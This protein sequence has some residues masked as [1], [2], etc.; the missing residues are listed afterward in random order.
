M[1]I[2]HS[3]NA[4]DNILFRLDPDLANHNVGPVQSAL[5]LTIGEFHILTE[6]CLH[7]VWTKIRPNKMSV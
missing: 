2:L 7:T 3:G 1:Y 4:T 5:Y 6:K